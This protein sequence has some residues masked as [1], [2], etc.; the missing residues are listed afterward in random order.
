MPKQQELLFGPEKSHV[1]INFPQAFALEK[2]DSSI[3]GSNDWLVRF[4]AIDLA[5]ILLPCSSATFGAV[6]EIAAVID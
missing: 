4:V 6:I 5:L 2:V 3:A 1:E